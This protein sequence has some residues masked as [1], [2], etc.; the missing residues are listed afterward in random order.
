MG[1]RLGAYLNHLRQQKDASVREVGGKIGISGPFLSLLERGKRDPSIRTLHAIVDVLDGDF[2]RALALLV[3]D[4]G[5]PVEALEGFDVPEDV[6]Q[7][8]EL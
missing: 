2:K 1:T 3:L 4:A 7:R 5:V 8:D 6:E